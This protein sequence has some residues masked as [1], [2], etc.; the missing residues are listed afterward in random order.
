MDTT[1][2]DLLGPFENYCIVQI[3][4]ENNIKLQSA[5]KILTTSF[6]CQFCFCK[7]PV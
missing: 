5:L 4:Y 7:L 1:Q 3:S 6:K 2:T